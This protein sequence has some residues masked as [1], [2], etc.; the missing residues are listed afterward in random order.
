[1]RMITQPRGLE[2]RRERQRD[3]RATEGRSSDA[4]DCDPDLD[5]REEAFRLIAERLDRDRAAVPRMRSLLHARLANTQDRD[6]CAREQ[7]IRDDECNDD[8]Q[9]RRHARELT[10]SVKLGLFDG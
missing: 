3:P 6:L 4:D 1:M 9:L 7:S 10:T 5:R 2:H 8:H